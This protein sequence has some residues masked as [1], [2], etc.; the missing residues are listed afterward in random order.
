VPTAALLGEAVTVDGLG[1]ALSLLART[2]PG[3]DAIRLAL[4]MAD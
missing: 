2:L 3:R 1:D 4:R